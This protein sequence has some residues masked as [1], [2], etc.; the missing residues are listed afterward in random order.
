MIDCADSTTMVMRQLS[1]R[2]LLRAY[3]E[4]CRALR[5]AHRRRDWANIAEAAYRLGAVA[6][7]L[8]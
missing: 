7:R 4:L 8:Q 3:G 2:E 5:E 6:G 1:R